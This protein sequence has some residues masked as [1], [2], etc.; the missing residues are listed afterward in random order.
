VRFFKPIL[1]IFLIFYSPLSSLAI[2]KDAL[3]DN[4]IFAAKKGLLEDTRSAISSG[5]DINKKRNDG[6]TPLLIAS[7]NGHTE[8]VKLLLESGADNSIADDYGFTPLLIASQ[9]SHIE[10]VKMLLESEA[11]V[12][13]AAQQPTV[14][15]H[16]KLHLK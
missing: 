12:N 15:L 8:I 3:S 7:L 10:I 9:K 13:I 1:I 5:A 2:E 11:D 4:L 16:L 14:Q 6:A